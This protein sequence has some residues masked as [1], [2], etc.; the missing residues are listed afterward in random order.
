MGTKAAPP[1]ANFFMG[2]QEET[3]RETFIWAIPFWKRFIDDIFLIF[4]GT[5]NQLQSLQD[6]M[7]HPHPYNQVHLSTLHPTNIL[8]RNEDSDWRKLQTFHNTVQKT[9]WLRGTSTLSLQPLT[10]IQR[11]HRF[12]TSSQIQLPHCRWSLTTK[13][14]QFSCNISPCQRISIR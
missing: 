3:I 1:Y 12:F 7:N 14:T 8:P 10:Q 4:L 11:K 9:H 2:C 13:R 5:S 6:F